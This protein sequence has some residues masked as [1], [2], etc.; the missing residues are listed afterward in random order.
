MKTTLRF[1]F[2][3][4]FRRRNFTF[5]TL[6]GLGTGVAV[7]LVIV[8][9]V[10]DELSYDR[11]HENKDR[12]YRLVNMGSSQGQGQGIAKVNGPWGITAKAEIPEVENVTRF[13]P[14]G[15]QLVQEGPN[16]FYENDGFFA[17]GSIFDVFTFRMLSGDPK[18]ALINAGSVVITKKFKEKYFGSGVALGEGLVVDGETYRVTGILE[19]IPQNSHFTF[20]YLITMES[21]Y[22]PDKH[23]WVRWNQFFTYVLL[24]EGG[25]PAAVEQKMRGIIAQHVDAEQV[26]QFGPALQ[27]LTSIH[28]HSHLLRELSAN[29]DVT[30]LY[31][32]G[33]VAFLILLIACSNFVNLFVAQATSR[34]REVGVRKVNGAGRQQLIGQFLS[35]TFVLVV[36]S[37]LLAHVIAG[38]ALPFI[39]I[40]AG[41]DLRIDYFTY[42]Q[43]L[44]AILALGSLVALTTGLYP[45]LLLSSLKPTFA[46][47]GGWR[48]AG[49]GKLRKTLV[50]AQFALSSFLIVASLIILQQLD[51]IHS[52]NPGFDPH[53]VVVVPITSPVF[54]S[55]LQTVKKELE[56]IPGVVR[57]SVSGN[58][59]GGSDWGIPSL[60]EGFTRDNMPEMRVMAVDADFVET[61]GM[62][63]AKGRDFSADLASDSG[64][65]LINE[66][67]ARVLQWTA[68]LQKQIAMPAIQRPAA[69]VIGVVNDFHFRSMH[70][71]IGPLLFF[72]PPAQWYSQY[73]IRI[74]ADQTAE[75]L[76][77]IQ[78][79]WEA[80][81]PEHPFTY[82]FFDQSYQRLY[83][84]DQQLSKLINLFTVIGVL[85]ACLGL[86][87][88]ATLTT[89]QR[90]K[91][92]GIRKVIGASNGQIVG[93]LAKN[94]AWLVLIG[95]AV[96]L[97]LGIWL[98]YRW[99]ATFA[100][101][102]VPSVL[103]MALGCIALML[104]ALIT[105]A[106]QSVHAA[107]R[108][109]VTSLR[110]E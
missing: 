52:R 45:A 4:L 104:V 8:F 6:L 108:N 51:Y 49:G 85:L 64:S 44:G 75:T 37:V 86:Y 13:V 81:D 32:F 21:Y 3:N 105:V 58:L 14:A 110:S 9:Y 19:D 16:R 71:R 107:A 2:R 74:S 102:A 33:S 77:R 91:E 93:M 76:K 34:A 92:I 78:A 25:N 103:L 66:E 90:T 98:G 89:A 7:C 26:A 27:P 70:E 73:S 82:S 50:V 84:Q 43:A 94:Y 67:A 106:G 88:L 83:Q 80:F 87:S 101:K 109:P 68:P 72:I 35:E 30:Y 42:P 17:D 100:Y 1:T 38:L 29:S 97:P 59:P 60:A 79:R 63:L 57:V 31:V 5:A 55:Q 95:F 46:M 62:S 23:N 28:L 47:K 41:K 22:H 40:L 96:A 10:L 99:L 39:N 18:L 65:Y 48:S 69:P 56:A 15:Q 54:R 20:S 61:Y 53:Q 11:Y 24:T 36:L 12:I